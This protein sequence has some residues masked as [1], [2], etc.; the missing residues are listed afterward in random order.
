MCLRVSFLECA[1]CILLILLGLKL[2]LGTPVLFCVYTAV[3]MLMLFILIY[4]ALCRSMLRRSNGAV[5]FVPG[6]LQK[7]P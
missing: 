4:A 1:P 7:T 5:A 6:P 2:L 3:V